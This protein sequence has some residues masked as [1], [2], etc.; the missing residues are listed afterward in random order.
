MTALSGARRP[1]RRVFDALSD[2][3]ADTLL[4]LPFL[5]ASVWFV[6]AFA[7]IAASRVT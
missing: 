2:L 7:W 1:F 3:D 5:G 6:F 4:L